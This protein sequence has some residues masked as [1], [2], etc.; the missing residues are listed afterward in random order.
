MIIPNII[1]YRYIRFN[2]TKFSFVDYV[3]LRSAYLAQK[4]DCIYLHTNVKEKHF[5]GVYWQWIAKSERDF[6]SRIIWQLFYGSDIA[7]LARIQILM[8]YGGI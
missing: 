8:K 7:I 1:H 2:Q 6:Y 3:Y 4:P 5:T